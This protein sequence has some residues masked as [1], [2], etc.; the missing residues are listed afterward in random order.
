M[1]NDLITVIAFLFGIAIVAA[2]AVGVY[3]GVLVIA[4]VLLSGT[5]GLLVAGWGAYRFYHTVRDY[6]DATAALNHAVETSQVDPS[7]LGLSRED[8]WQR[9]LSE[10]NVEAR[11][12]EEHPGRYLFDYQGGHFYVDIDKSAF[13]EVYYAFIEELD[14]S[15]IDEVSLIRRAINEANFNACPTLVYSTNEEEDKMYVHMLQSVLL[16]PQ[17][18]QLKDY[19]QSRLTVF[20]QMQ[21][22]FVNI[23]DRLRQEA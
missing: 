4:D 10:L 18:P 15:D 9:V 17:I 16:L 2:C 13:A 20:F 14:L 6:N 19:L 7:Y 1:R 5:I 3:N 23:L 22:H 12:D 11:P 21:R 8:L